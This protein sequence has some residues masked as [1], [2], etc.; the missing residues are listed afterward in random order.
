MANL[1]TNIPAAASKVHLRVDDDS[2]L[3]DSERIL[4]KSLES[5]T[6]HQPR[7]S[8]VTAVDMAWTAYGCLMSCSNIVA[9]RVPRRYPRMLDMMMTAA[10][11]SMLRFFLKQTSRT[12]VIVSIVSRSSSSILASLQLSATT[13]CRMAKV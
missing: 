10:V 5:P 2:L 13:A 4:G 11:N 12:I 3:A 9:P 8:V 6:T 7:I 1:R